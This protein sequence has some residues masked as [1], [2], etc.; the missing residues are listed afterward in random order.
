MRNL[1][2]QFSAL[3]QKE[4]AEKA[5]KQKSLEDWDADPEAENERRAEQVAC[6]F[7]FGNTKS[8]RD[9]HGS[10]S[11]SSSSG[12]DSDS[13]DSDS[14]SGDSDKETPAAIAQPFAAKKTPLVDPRKAARDARKSRRA[15]RQE[16][17]ATR[18]ERRATRLEKDDKERSKEEKENPSAHPSVSVENAST[19]SR[20]EGQEKN[21]IANVTASCDTSS[22]IGHTS[23]DKI[24]TEESAVQ[25]GADERGKAETNAQS[26]YEFGFRGVF[27]DVA[28]SAMRAAIARYINAR[29]RSFRSLNEIKYGKSVLMQALADGE[30]DVAKYIIVTAGSEKCKQ[31]ETFT[32]LS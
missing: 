24:F 4:E 11:S 10:S 28:P 12:S 29:A 30:V 32:V 31:W 8:G 21:T 7:G 25:G 22:N 27:E 17:R 16:R 14:D 15:T 26:E 2:A 6:G 13:S 9:G 20:T 19:T 23:H 1:D 5:R 3:G 18:L